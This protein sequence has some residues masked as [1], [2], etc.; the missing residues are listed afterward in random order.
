VFADNVVE[1]RKVFF[2]RVY[3]MCILP[4]GGRDSAPGAGAHRLSDGG[5]TGNKK[6]AAVCLL[7]SQSQDVLVSPCLL[8]VNCDACF[9]L[10]FGLRLLVPTKSGNSWCLGF[11]RLK[12]ECF[13]GHINEDER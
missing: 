4:K 12:W 3:Y 10:V 13:I 11:W 7:P 8:F 6:R 5:N 1:L 9:P 2:P